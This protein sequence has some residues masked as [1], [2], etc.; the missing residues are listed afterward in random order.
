MKFNYDK[1]ADA[2]YLKVKDGKIASTKEVSDKLLVDVDKD[3]N[4]LGIELLDAS[5]QKD[6]VM[7]LEKNVKGGVPVEISYATPQIA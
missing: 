6:M 2:V 1:I 3:G 7:N 4:I 5:N